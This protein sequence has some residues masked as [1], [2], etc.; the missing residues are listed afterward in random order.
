MAL[1]PEIVAGYRAAATILTSD[2]RGAG[3]CLHSPGPRIHLATDA[4]AILDAVPGAYTVEAWPQQAGI[5]LCWNGR[6][7]FD[8][9]WQTVTYPVA[10]DDPV[11][12]HR[13]REPL[14]AAVADY[15]AK[16][17]TRKA[18]DAQGEPGLVEARDAVREVR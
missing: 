11:F 14:L 16:A 10:H 6:F 13:L 17:E 5:R 18:E 8:V 9:D 12:A 7:G 15:K 4:A 2:P 3:I 1:H